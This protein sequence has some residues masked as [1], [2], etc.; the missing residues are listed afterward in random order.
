MISDGNAVWDTFWQEVW[1]RHNKFGVPFFDLCRNS[2]KF[3]LEARYGVLGGFV[4][5]Q[6]FGVIADEFLWR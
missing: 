2:F 3:L 5:K 1:I 6:F 4:N